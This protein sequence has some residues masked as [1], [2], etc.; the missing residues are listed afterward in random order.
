MASQIVEAIL[1]DAEK[2]G[3]KSIKEVVLEVG[4][5]TFL[6]PEQLRFCCENL[7]KGTLLEGARLIIKEVEGLVECKKCG[8]RG[9]LNYEDDPLYHTQTP[10]FFCPSCGSEVRIV[11]GKECVVKS[12]KVVV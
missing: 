11:K 3:V 2:R 7:A 5:F 1:G 8:Y 6:R 9:P 4:T 10:S 12:I